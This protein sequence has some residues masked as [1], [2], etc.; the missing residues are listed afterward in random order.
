MKIA[1]QIDFVKQLKASTN[2]EHIRA[3]HILETCGW[4]LKF[5]EKIIKEED[6]RDMTELPYEFDLH[7]DI[8][9]TYQL[10]QYIQNAKDTA[11]NLKVLEGMLKEYNIKVGE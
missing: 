3:R 5:A 2:C 10:Q 7:F 11:R 4:D 6:E 9:Y 1:E 8:K